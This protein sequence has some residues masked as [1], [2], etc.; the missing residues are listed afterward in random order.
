MTGECR[1]PKQ[2]TGKVSAYLKRRYAAVL[3]KTVRFSYKKAGEEVST[4]GK[5]VKRLTAAILAAA[6]I[7]SVGTTV[8]AAGSPTK[9]NN[10]PDTI[11]TTKPAEKSNEVKVVGAQSTKD[12][13]FIAGKQNGKYVKVIAKH[14]VKK[15]KKYSKI[16][17]ELYKRTRVKKDVL[18]GKSKKSKK[19]VIKKAK[20]AKKL[21]AKHFS[22]YAFRGYKGTIVV[23]KS[24]M[25]R[26]QFNLLK[27]KLRNGGCK[28]KI[29]YKK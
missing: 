15:D 18:T 10:T 1:I 9:G 21:V 26:T 20:T 8:F 14:T 22:K 13:L 2:K 29:T 4:M 25:T 16:T 23:K 3:Y 11:I 5:A 28:A 12:T 17:F 7:M 19:I 6:M 27:K 24:A